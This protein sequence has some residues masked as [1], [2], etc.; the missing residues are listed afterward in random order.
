MATADYQADTFCNDVCPETSLRLIDEAVV[1]WL[2]GIRFRDQT[3]R[4]VTGWTSREFA[5]HHE[6]DPKQQTKQAHSWPVISVFMSSITP[7]LSRR[8]VSQISALGFDAAS[9]AH[10]QP[11]GTSG[12]LRIKHGTSD[13]ELFVLPFPLPYEM[14]YQ[15]D[16]WTKTQQDMQ[17]LRSA[18]LSRFPYVDE[19]FLKIE[20]P[21]G[22]PG[23]GSKLIPIKLGRVDDLTDLEPDEGRREIR[24]TI[25]FTALGWIFRVPIKKKTIRA[26][27]TVLIDAG[28]EAENLYDC[29]DFLQ[30]Y[31]NI[32]HYAIDEDGV[33]QS[34]TE[35]PD[36]TPPNRVLAWMSWRDGI[37]QNT[38]P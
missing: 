37:L 11:C 14:S 23:Y 1:G 2:S 28:S 8:S 21:K 29:S 38:G 15:I 10:N 34:V 30:W 17:W 25:S 19:G 22:K 9:P 13:D 31:C 27:N 7:D 24:N 33:L 4:V 12:N 6:I 36:L 35:S 3:P 32:D 16:I 18:I 20:F 26:I 5:Q